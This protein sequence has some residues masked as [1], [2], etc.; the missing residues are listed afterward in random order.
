MTV[1]DYNKCLLPALSKSWNIAQS[2]GS[3][4]NNNNMEI[5]NQDAQ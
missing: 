5:L 2:L 4:H 3:W 1:D